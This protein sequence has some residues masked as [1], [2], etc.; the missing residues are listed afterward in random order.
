MNASYIASQ[1]VLPLDEAYLQR[2]GRGLAQV[3]QQN[4][5][6]RKLLLRRAIREQRPAPCV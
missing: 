5:D 3:T 1:G 2:R 4:R 6:R